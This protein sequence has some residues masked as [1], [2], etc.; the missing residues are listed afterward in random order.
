MSYKTLT[1]TGKEFILKIC[2]GDGDSLLSGS[3]SYK[4]SFS[5]DPAGTPYT[6]NPTINGQPITT[7]FQLGH[8]LIQ[9]FNKYAQ[10]YDIDANIVAAQ[11]YIE[12]NYRLWAFPSGKGVNVANKSSA[13]GITQF[14]SKTLYDVVI[15]NNGVATRTSTTFTQDEKNKLTNG[16]TDPNLL[17]SYIYDTNSST[18][19]TAKGNRV[20]FFQNCMDNPD[21]MIKAQCRLVKG[22]S[23]KSENNAA[24]TLFG[25]NQGPAYVRGTFTATLKNAEPD[26]LSK[27]RYNDGIKYVEKIFRVLGDP[28]STVQGKPKGISFGYTIDFT[29]DEFL[30]DVAS[31]NSNIRTIDRSLELSTNYKLQDL[32]TTDGKRTQLNVPTEAEY[33]KLKK[34]ANV[35]LEPINDLIYPIYGK[36]LH[37][38]SSFRSYAINQAVGGVNDSQHKKAEA[39]DVR[40]ITGDHEALYLIFKQL[41][42]ADKNDPD[43]IKYDQLIYETKGTA[44]PRNWIHISYKVDN[45]SGNKNQNKLATLVGDDMKYELYTNQPRPIA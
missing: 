11:A 44:I 1:N 24:S 6:A 19:P 45:P 23:F 3:N 28:N 37:V 43:T 12:S 42:N 36:I 29:F 35:V 8:S 31:S 13:Q 10:L 26:T 20:Q 16:L 33:E 40:L 17:S 25:Y 4:L 27:T 38:N 14:L 5:N 7:N 34:F 39:A 9:W 22:I 21:L 30:A 2:E 41:A 15:G 32:V 18:Y